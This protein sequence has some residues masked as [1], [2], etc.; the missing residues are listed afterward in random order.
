MGT[1]DS[2]HPL[3][4]QYLIRKP[5]RPGQVPIAPVKNG[6]HE[7]VAPRDDV[8]DQPEVGRKAQLVRAVTLDEIDANRAQL[9]AHRRIDVGVATGDA[10]SGLLRDSRDAA[11]EGAADAE[12]VEMHC[13]RA[14]V[15]GNAA[16]VR[17]GCAIIAAMSRTGARQNGMRAR[18]AAAA[19]RLMAEDGIAD[20][21]L[22]K[23]KAARSLGAPHTEALPGNDEIE[24]ELRAYLAL[25]QASE[26]PERV[27]A[28]V[29]PAD[30]P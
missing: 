26:H 9:S 12:D 24:A 25:Y 27:V 16:I 20:F 3:T 29:V 23:R 7:R 15:R 11:H 17:E 5:L 13:A 10:V 6:L 2:E 14:A 21:A 22:A 28:A 30:R 8:A 19:A 4:K 1:S 18:I